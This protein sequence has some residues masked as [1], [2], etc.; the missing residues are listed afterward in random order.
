M[1]GLNETELDVLEGNESWMM[2]S[3]S[4]GPL[5]ALDAREGASRDG[6]EERGENGKYEFRRGR[7]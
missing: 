3:R 5:A 1:C 2:A 7:V 6:G 4:A